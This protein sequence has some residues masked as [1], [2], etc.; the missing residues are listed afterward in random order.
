MA[1]TESSIQQGASLQYEIAQE[2]SLEKSLS[3]SVFSLQSDVAVL[4]HTCNTLR[5]DL[6]SMEAASEHNSTAAANAAVRV[7]RLHAEHSALI[8]SH[9]TLTTEVATFHARNN[10][11][12]ASVAQLTHSLNEQ[13]IEALSVNTAHSHAFAEITRLETDLNT[14]R[15]VSATEL[16]RYARFRICF[17]SSF[18][19][20]DCLN[21]IISDKTAQLT[22][23]TSS[24]AALE[25][26]VVL[27]RALS[28]L[29]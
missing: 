29:I 9:E 28:F 22:K 1:D 20:L 27:L 21:A 10:E 14:I 7:S 13:A 6:S 26:Q 24:I 8:E 12:V 4:Q 19:L 15:A 5:S 11:L 3:E 25:Q 17:S 16:A 23:Y 2:Q 18:I